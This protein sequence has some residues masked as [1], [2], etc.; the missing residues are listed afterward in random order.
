MTVLYSEQFRAELC[1]ITGRYRA[2]DKE[3]GRRFVQTVEQAVLDIRSDPLRWRV[4]EGR[5]PARSRRQ[6][7]PDL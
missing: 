5:G 1:C 6:H 2:E 4:F 3:L 7:F